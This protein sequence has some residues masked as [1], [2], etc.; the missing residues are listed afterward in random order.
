[1]NKK[2][3]RRLLWWLCWGWLGVLGVAWWIMPASA[4]TRT[5]GIE[6][7]ADGETV[8]GIVSISGTA[9]D[10]NFL[11]YELAFRRELGGDWIVFAE[12]DQPVYAGTLALWDTTVGR[13]TNAAVFPDGAYQLRLRVVRQDYNYDEY[14][15]SG[16]IISNDTPTATPTI[17]TTVTVTPPAST[18]ATP[19]AVPSPAALPSLTPFPTLTP[20]AAPPGDVVP[21]SPE[22]G[23]GEGA[24]E[25]GGLLGQ[26]AGIDAGR[27]S[28]A[29]WA[30]VRVT[31]ILFAI[32]GLYVFLRALTRWLRRLPTRRPRS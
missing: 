23:R 4:Q 12:G 1:M 9:A 6:K 19:F 32:G 20:L 25:T 3:R 26:L 24:S 31:G 14:V 2:D 28:R 10:P 21:I 7:P 5:N 8:A 22:R 18:G 11:R 13:N 17:T 15:V 30:G 16:V 29:F 27:F